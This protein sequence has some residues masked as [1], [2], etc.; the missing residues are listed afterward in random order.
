MVKQ[1]GLILP[2]DLLTHLLVLTVGTSRGVIHAK[3]PKDLQDIML[4]TF[5]V[6]RHFKQDLVIFN[7][8]VDEEE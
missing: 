3:K 7:T 6:T 1:E 2:I 4:P 5:D 8:A